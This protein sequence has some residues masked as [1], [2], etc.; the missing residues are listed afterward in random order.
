MFY[1]IYFLYYINK[2]VYY[3]IISVNIILSFIEQYYNLL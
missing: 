2:K 3:D 1:I